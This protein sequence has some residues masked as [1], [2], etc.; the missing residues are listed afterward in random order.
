[1]TKPM[2]ATFADSEFEAYR[3]TTRREQFLSEMDRVVP[4]QELCALVEPVY[5]KGEGPGR[6]TVGLERML[7]TH[8][9]QHWYDLSDPAVEEALYDSNA[10]RRFV[11]IDLGR[12]SVPDET[13]VC[14]FRHLLE[15]HGLG[16]RIFE[17]VGRYLQQQGFKLSRG[18]IVDAT[19]ISAPSSTKNKDK[20]RD[21]EMHQTKKGNQ[22]Y[23]GMKAH[24]GVDAKDKLIHSV[25]ATAANVA[26][27]KVLPQLLR[28]DETRV[29]GDKAYCGQSDSIREKSPHAKD[30]T[31]RKAHRNRPLTERQAQANH[32][33]SKTRS[34]VEHPFLV[35][36][37]VWGFAKVRYRG[38]M[39]NANRLFAACALANLF[40][41]RKRLLRLQGA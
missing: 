29:Y 9:L 28:G 15:E 40:R 41:V 35:L 18:T 4:W 21:P 34:K 2:Q 37:R 36:K 31:Q 26:D 6:P 22:W 24:I 38:L 12:E 14:K 20:A 30:F 25:V 10:M 32:T 1:M 11:G 23:F 27:S 5:P 19:I 33:K 16:K 13:T 8:F 7:R 17:E 39:K 3:K